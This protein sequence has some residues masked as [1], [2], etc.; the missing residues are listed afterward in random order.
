MGSVAVRSAGPAAPLVVTVM[1]EYAV[2]V[3]ELTARLGDEGVSVSWQHTGGGNWVAGLGAFHGYDEEQG[4]DV[5][6]VMIGPVYRD[7]GGVM[8]GYT[9][10]L[11]VVANGE[12][13]T[14]TDSGESLESMVRGVL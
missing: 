9:G 7:E 2:D 1:D 4:A 5:Y 10:D 12:T 8:V 11:Y 6:D 13:Q 14:V 3:S